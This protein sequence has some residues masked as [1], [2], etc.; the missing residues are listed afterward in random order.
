MTK[1]FTAGLAAARKYKIGFER[2]DQAAT[3]RALEAAGYHWNRDSG[4]WED[5]GAMAANPATE[6]IRLRVWAAGGVVE[7]I[8]DGVSE[9][10]RAAG[11]VLVERSAAYPCRPPQQA[12]SRIYLSF[13]PRG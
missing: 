4:K 1:K 13:R 6:L 11:L 2:N 3:Y 12:E 5:W 9:A 7:M 10:M 8:A